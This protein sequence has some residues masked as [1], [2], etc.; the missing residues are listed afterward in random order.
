MASDYDSD[1]HH[2]QIRAGWRNLA[3]FI[4]QR[5]QDAGVTPEQIAAAG[6]PSPRGLA[7]YLN[8]RATT[9]RASKARAL[10]RALGWAPL[11]VDLIRDG[12]EPTVTDEQEP[13]P[14]L[15]ELGRRIR[16]RRSDLSLSQADVAAAG[17]PSTATLR[18]IE[19]G[20]HPRFRAS[21]SES[22]E[23]ILGWRYGTIHATL[24]GSPLPDDSDKLV[25]ATELANSLAAIS[26]AIC[27]VLPRL[28]PGDRRRAQLGQAISAIEHAAELG[29]PDTTTQT[30]PEPPEPPN[31]QPPS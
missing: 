31:E 6:G 25:A 13:D 17:G 15:V 5:M 12:G 22:L 20:K 29:E 28:T 27:D 23:R 2:R 4:T 26:A 19:K 14:A 8:E 1:E 21:T 3:R 10:E 7:D 24:S 30:D 11:D 16:Q 18:L 9:L